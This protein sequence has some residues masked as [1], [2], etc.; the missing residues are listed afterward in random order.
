MRHPLGT[1]SLGRDVL[2]RLLWGG[3]VSL[4]VGCAS[5]V[6]AVVIG[7]CAG[8]LAGYFRGATD[9]LVG[10]A[11][12]VLESFPALFLIVVAVALLAAH[13]VRPELAIVAVIGLHAWIGVARLVRAECLRTSQLD[14][15]L[16]ARA[17]GFSHA[18]ILARH[19]VP[20][21]IAP[22]YVTA[23][24][25]VTAAIAFESATS[26]LGF[27]VRPPT[28]SWGAVLHESQSSA[29]WWILVFPGL[30]VFAACLACNWIGDALRDHFDPREVT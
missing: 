12:G 13:G 29:H 1:D 30:L 26:F 10:A 11:I 24:F 8:A 17:L 16:A 27:G 15:V 19:V 14:Y 22:V 9:A 20:N 3:R 4:L 25:W 28:P 23:A 18:R 7:V 21:S 6:L 2:V 5:V